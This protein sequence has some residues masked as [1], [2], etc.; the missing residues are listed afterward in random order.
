MSPASS[1]AFFRLWRRNSYG[2]QRARKTLAGLFNATGKAP[3]FWKRV[4]IR[5]LLGPDWA[6]S[7]NAAVPSHDGNKR[8]LADAAIGA[9]DLAKIDSSRTT[10]SMEPIIRKQMVPRSLSSGSPMF[11]ADHEQATR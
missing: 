11:G 2:A 7:H 4:I 5:L 10:L 3:A 1:R 6:A 8:R 9:G